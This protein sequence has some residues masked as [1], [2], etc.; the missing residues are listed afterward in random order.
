MIDMQAGDMVLYE[1]ARCVHGRPFNLHGK[2]WVNVFVHFAPKQW[3]RGVHY[4]VQGR[5]GVISHK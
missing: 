2:N 1:G 3:T 5:F 4:D